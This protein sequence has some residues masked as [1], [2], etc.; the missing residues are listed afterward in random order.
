MLTLQQIQDQI[1]AI[2]NMEKL[3]KNNTFG[4]LSPNDK[5]NEDRIY[6][7]YVG[8]IANVIKY[9]L[10]QTTVV[11]GNWYT[12]HTK[13]EGDL[14]KAFI[15]KFS[16]T[17]GF[18]EKLVA[19]IKSVFFCF[20]T[21]KSQVAEN[22]VYQYNTY[23][24][25]L[26]NGGADDGVDPP[27]NEATNQEISRLQGQIKESNNNLFAAQTRI[28]E[29]EGRIKAQEEGKAANQPVNN[30]INQLKIQRE[31][32]QHEL[33]AAQKQLKDAK[34]AAPNIPQLNQT[35][36]Q[37]QNQVNNLEGQLKKAQDDLKQANM[38]ADQLPNLQNEI[39]TLRGKVANNE[40]TIVN[41]NVR[42]Q[43]LKDG[44]NSKPVNDN[45]EIER[46]EGLLQ[47]SQEE[48]LQK[49]TRIANLTKQLEE[50]TTS[51]EN[52][53]KRVDELNAT[54]QKAQE[55]A[56]KI[57]QLNQTIQQIRNQVADLEGQLK[58]ARGDLIEANEKATR[59]PAL[60]NEIGGL[61]N[62]IDANKETI[63]RL[64][65]RIKELENN[66]PKPKDDIH[67]GEIE[68][69]AASLRTSEQ[70][71]LANRNKVVDLTNELR[72]ISAS[73]ENAEK[74]IDELNASLQKAQEEAQKIPDL[75]QTIQHIRNQV[76]D[77]EGQLKKAQNNYAEADAKAQQVP[78]LQN[79][80][81][82]L[83]NTIDANRKTID[84]LN[85]RIKEL[86]N[87]PIPK[88]NVVID[89]EEINRL[90]GLLQTLQQEN[91]AN[92]NR[93]AELTN[94]LKQISELKDNAV[95]Q[96]DE[97]NNTLRDVRKE[98]SHLYETIKTKD[99]RIQELE[100]NENELLQKIAGY[101]NQIEK[102]REDSQKEIQHLR[103][104]LKEEQKQHQ[105]VI[106]ENK[107]LQKQC[108]E[109]TLKLEEEKKSYHEQLANFRK[110]FEDQMRELRL[111]LEQ[112]R[113]ELSKKS[114]DYADSLN[115]LQSLIK[116]HADEKAIFEQT[117]NKYQEEKNALNQQISILKTALAEATHA[118]NQIARD[119]NAE[120]QKA[121]N[122]ISELERQLHEA[123]LKSQ[124]LVNSQR[125]I[126][127]IDPKA[128][129]PKPKAVDRGLADHF[130]N[131]KS[132]APG[133]VNDMQ[134]IL[135]DAAVKANENLSE[136]I[137]SS[138]AFIRQKLD[139]ISEANRNIVKQEIDNEMKELVLKLKDCQEIRKKINRIQ[140]ILEH[141][142]V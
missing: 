52:A 117:K 58:I 60:Q 80:I 20:F 94:Q 18:G 79:Q 53:E 56:Q 108:A 68:R 138:I 6:S 45:T 78:A 82:G 39:E 124:T 34:A 7:V 66:T 21:T 38:K 19:C 63:D 130:K 83:E 70:E 136:T 110:I 25:R 98:L 118:K 127:V 3:V 51:K 109:L 105:K 74:R 61:E 126:G 62:T 8:A 55:E 14:K 133:Y 50:I 95:K 93:A 75:N 84:R 2:Q 65:A 132:K 103:N 91:I 142:M 42:I 29:L 16:E 101:Q 85:A 137:K 23:C 32:V 9:Y 1:S 69:L 5:D 37:K 115:S 114:V 31:Q 54:L 97:L 43:Q 122:R 125:K 89:N 134:A 24:D 41:L 139:S 57:P 27:Q 12:D 123:E 30:N 22:L 28:K 131:Y 120:L 44:D 10:D 77:L 116:Q 90:E 128:G 119:N 99:S 73:K 86:E 100:T 67:E 140:V 36:T 102:L 113:E 26:E 47:T 107:Q 92:R 76:A 121:A 135:D 15:T 96:V 35:I 71:L 11:Q 46:L 59:V 48:I 141:L 33:E 87:T 4:K 81:G 106:E 49:T 64:N 72:Q 104:Q 88:P 129:Q 13:V 40:K 112:A 111:D 17:S